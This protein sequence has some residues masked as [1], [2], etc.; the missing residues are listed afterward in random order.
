MKRLAEQSNFFS[1]HVNTVEPQKSQV[2]GFFKIYSRFLESSDFEITILWNLGILFFFDIFN[3]SPCV[4]ILRDSTVLWICCDI[5]YKQLC[6]CIISLNDNCEFV[7]FGCVI[8]FHLCCWL[9]KKSEIKIDCN[10]IIINST[11]NGSVILFSLS[12]NSL[13]ASSMRK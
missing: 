4:K 10:E 12:F 5:V 2:I 7:S 8:R 9:S 13:M 11:G 1:H 6:V 3:I